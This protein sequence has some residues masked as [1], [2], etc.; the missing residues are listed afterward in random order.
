MSTEMWTFDGWKVLGG[1]FLEVFKS[2]ILQHKLKAWKVA[3]FSLQYHCYPKDGFM[4]MF[5]E[6]SFLTPSFRVYRRM[7][8]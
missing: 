2:D 1:V 7:C 5:Y 6:E 8:Q 3:V 4:L